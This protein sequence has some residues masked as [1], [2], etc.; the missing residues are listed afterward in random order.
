MTKLTKIEVDG[1]T[2]IVTEIELTDAEVT[3][4]KEEA[5]ALALAEKIKQEELEAKA[6]AKSALLSKL[7]ITAEEVTLLL[8]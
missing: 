4:L 7:G 2:G 8:S 6:S 1:V 3:Q 5:K